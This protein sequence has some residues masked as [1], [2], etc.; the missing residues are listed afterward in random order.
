MSKLK[1][2]ALPFFVGAVA[3]GC[4]PYTPIKMELHTLPSLHSYYQNK[5]V[6]GF[7]IDKVV[8]NRIDK[9]SLGMFADHPVLSKNF[10]T[11]VKNSFMQMQKTCH[12]NNCQALSIKVKIKKAY[13]ESEYD[14]INA[15]ILIDIYYYR[16]G[17]F[18]NKIAYHGYDT[19]VNW[20]GSNND[21][22]R[23]LSNALKIILNKVA[24]DIK[25]L[26]GSVTPEL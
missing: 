1:K 23:P 19:S 16:N 22:T 10:S 4:S 17:K 13:V 7:H 11:W 5:L 2:I 8:D 24:S 18:I 25:R 21:Y 20:A 6:A 3:G 14:V 12:T 9:T 26:Q 15:N